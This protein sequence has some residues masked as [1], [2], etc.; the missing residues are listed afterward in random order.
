MVPESLHTHPENVASDL[1]F[2][3]HARKIQGMRQIKLRNYET[4][5]TMQMIM[6][7]VACSGSDSIISL[8]LLHSG[9]KQRLVVPATAQPN[10][11]N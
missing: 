3:A 2:G 10:F 11:K 7:N 6:Q 1:H 4:K 9:V 5:I 8:K